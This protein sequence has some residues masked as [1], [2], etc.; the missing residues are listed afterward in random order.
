M[1]NQLL[2]VHLLSHNQH[3]LSNSA[4]IIDDNYSIGQFVVPIKHSP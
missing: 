2:A 3:I 4:V 1:N